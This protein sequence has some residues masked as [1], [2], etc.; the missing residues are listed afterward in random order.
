MNTKD[1]IKHLKSIGYFVEPIFPNR[2]KIRR[3]GQ[4][5]WPWVSQDNYSA[6]ELVKFAKRYSSENNQSSAM[7][8][9][10]KKFDKSKAR[11]KTRNLLA[12]KD[13]EKL[14]ELGP[15]AKVKTEDYQNWN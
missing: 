10:V 4:S 11:A 6:R 9:N 14:D 15:L 1:A 7:K 2:Y 3:V 8:K 5:D 12:T 13:E